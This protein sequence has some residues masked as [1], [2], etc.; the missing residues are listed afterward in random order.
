MPLWALTF[1]HSGKSEQKR[2]SLAKTDSTNQ[3][4]V[5]FLLNIRRRQPKSFILSSSKCKRFTTC[6]SLSFAVGLY[7]QAY[8]NSRRHSL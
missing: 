8:A 6:E 3:R 1:A 5:S 7:V 2:I 4:K